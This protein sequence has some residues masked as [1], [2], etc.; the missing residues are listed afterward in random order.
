MHLITILPN[1]V[2]R[3]KLGRAT[4]PADLEALGILRATSLIPPGEPNLVGWEGY[5]HWPMSDGSRVNLELLEDAVEWVLEGLRRKRRT[6]V[7]CRAGRNRTGLV[8]ATVL[9]RWLGV[10]GAEALAMF[11]ARRPRGVANPAFEEYLLGLP[12]G[13]PRRG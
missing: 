10:S 5:A 1:L 11:R 7:M 4:R 2:T 3:G 8:V 9:H 6:L 13:N 12:K